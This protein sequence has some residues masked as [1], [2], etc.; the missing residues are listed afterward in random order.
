MPLTAPSPRPWFANGVRK[1]KS[2]AMPEAGE[3]AMPIRW[4][5]KTQ[6]LS[7]P[8]YKTLGLGKPLQQGNHLGVKPGRASSRFRDQSWGFSQGR[9]SRLP[10]HRCGMRLGNKES[11]QNSGNCL[12]MIDS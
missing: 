1:A 11:P 9:R 3:G 10:Q 8:S 2:Q 4:Q 7:P 6:G 5:R 12:C